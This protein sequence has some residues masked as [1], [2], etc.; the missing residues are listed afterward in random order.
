M[1]TCK[2]QTCHQN[3]N[4]VAGAVIREAQGSVGA[5][6]DPNHEKCAITKSTLGLLIETKCPSLQVLR[7]VRI[8]F[9]AWHT[10]SF[11]FLTGDIF[12]GRVALPGFHTVLMA[13]KPETAYWLGK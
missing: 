11:F 1:L 2:R 8:A 13:F 9:A 10:P 12:L 7:F 6:P 5:S 4:S 3:D